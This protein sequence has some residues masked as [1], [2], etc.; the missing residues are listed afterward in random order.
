MSSV[1]PTVARLRPFGS[2]IFAE[3]TELAVRHDAVNLGQGFPDTDGPA[4]MLEVARAAI[5]DGHNQY[6]P[7]RGVPALRRAVADDRARRYGTRYDPD[8]EVLVTVGATEAISATLLGL[9]E[10]GAEVVLIEPYYDSY[11]AAVALA[12]AQRRTA[13]LVPDGDRFV[14]DLDSLR[15]AITPKTRMLV[16]NS[17]HNPTG[18]VLSRDELAAIAELAREHDLLVLAD[19]VYEHLV[20]D[21]VEHISISTLPGMRE[22][23]IVVSSAAKTFN[24]TGWKIGW[25]CAPA[26]LLNAVLTAKQFMTFVGGGPFQPAVAHA[27]DTELDWVRGMRD[28]L[29]DKRLRLS[30]ALRDTG[31]AVSST[32]GGYFVCAD[33]RPLGI[34]DGL[35]LCREMPA[36]FGV[37]AVPVSAF[38][39]HP[40][41]WKHLV[42]FTFSK[43]DETID[44]G[45]RRLRA[46]VATR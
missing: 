35:T 44:E 13:R 46:G 38:V 8:T 14:L 32:A 43:R 36:R 16:I 30:D 11:A 42:R 29:A 39:D 10:P 24:V 27:I 19:E 9:V 45:A 17:P 18:S 25:A 37:A 1:P 41:E 12:G 5:A 6:P 26:P 20:Y 33:V 7:G 4:S 34:D 15:S 21:G 3:M 40:D 2:T 28:G 22:R 23:T 31:F